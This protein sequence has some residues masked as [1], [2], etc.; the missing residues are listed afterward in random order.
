M[1]VRSAAGLAMTCF[2]LHGSAARHLDT[3]E[4]AVMR[5]CRLPPSAGLGLQEGRHSAVSKGQAVAV[6]AGPA[7]QDSVYNAALDTTGPL[8]HD[9]SLGHLNPGTFHP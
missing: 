6:K 3:A 5:R 2:M 7:T 9:G 1:C 8:T 4:A